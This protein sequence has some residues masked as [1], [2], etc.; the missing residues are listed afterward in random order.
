MGLKVKLYD[1]A[2]LVFKCSQLVFLQ[3]TVLI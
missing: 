2:V 1:G 3:E